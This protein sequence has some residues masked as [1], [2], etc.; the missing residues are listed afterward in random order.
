M[1]PCSY[2][3]VPASHPQRFAKAL[4]TPAGAVIVD[5]EDAVAGP[6]KPAARDALVAAAPSLAPHGERVWLRL[7][8]RDSAHFA[9]DVELLRALRPLLP[10]LGIVLPKAE[11]ADD[12]RALRA[13]C[14]GTSVAA[15]IESARGL[16]H[17]RTIAQTEGVTRLVFGSIDYALDLGGLDAD[18]AEAMLY[19]RSTLVFVS[20]LAGL[21]A[22]ADG[23]TTAID[24]AAKLEADAARA[25]RL[26]FGAKLCIHPRQVE[27]VEAAF[28]PT[29]AEL[30]WARRIVAASR[31]AGE[32]VVQLDGAMV[33]RPVVLRAERLLAAA[34]E[35]P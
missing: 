1:L 23:V 27:T 13:A 29:S 9:A 8:A 10:Q 34:G 6:A 24:D 31:A 2:L 18:D 33:D 20:R 19:A 16:D 3:F 30:A 25:R 14:P 32:G 12:V 35:Q 7:N 11:A 5:L 22:P 26:G 17:A 4:A 21:P 15:L 28:R